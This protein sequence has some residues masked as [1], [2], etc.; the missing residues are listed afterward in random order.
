LIVLV[1]PSLAATCRDHHPRHIVQGGP[2]TLAMIEIG[3][4]IETETGTGIGIGR[5]PA[6]EEG[7]TTQITAVE[8]E[9]GVL[10]D[11]D[12]V[13]GIEMTVEGV[14]LGV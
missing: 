11:V 8:G 6:I 7:I 2:T 12:E 10:G 14:I 5:R 3:T 9:E 13:E 1:N 4:G